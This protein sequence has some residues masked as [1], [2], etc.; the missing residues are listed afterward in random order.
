MMTT[1]VVLSGMGF[2]NGV[3][4]KLLSSLKTGTEGSCLLFLVLVYARARA[5]LLPL[6]IKWVGA[7]NQA[8][9]RARLGSSK[10][11]KRNAMSSYLPNLTTA[12]NTYTTYQTDPPKG[13]SSTI[14]CFYYFY[15]YKSFC[16]A[17]YNI[18][19]KL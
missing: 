5:T 3:G 11:K 16:C 14:L 9:A 19:F 4:S 2:P 17:F 10:K 7:S 12:E 15:D 8:Q 13:A 1:R 18:N 6:Y